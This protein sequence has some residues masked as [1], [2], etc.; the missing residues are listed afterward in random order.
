M[1]ETEDREER[2]KQTM[3]VKT[4]TIKVSSGP[5]PLLVLLKILQLSSG[6]SLALCT[7]P[8]DTTAEQ[9]LLPV[10]SGK[11]GLLLNLLIQSVSPFS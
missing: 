8:W 4:K 2:R 7:C 1:R 3:E 5:S 6:H 9:M 10:P 11:K